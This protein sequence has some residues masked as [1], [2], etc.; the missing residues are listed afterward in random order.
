MIRSLLILCIPFLL[1]GCGIYSFTGDSID[2]TQVSTISISTFYNDAGMGP[3][4]LSQTFTEALRDYYV[5]NSKLTLTESNGDLQLEGSITGYNTRLVTPVSSATNADVNDPGL[6]RLTI[7]VKAK[8]VNTTDNTFDFD[9]TFSFYA[10]YDPN[11]ES[12]I[13][14]VQ[15]L[16]EE[17]TNQLVID[18][19][20]ASVANW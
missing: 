17:T 19:F 12:F 16:I 8:Y 9:Q 13:S 1:N 14:I 11:R 3:P 2:Y 10:D 5:R 6:E 15:L 4:N 7:T 18:I 20:T